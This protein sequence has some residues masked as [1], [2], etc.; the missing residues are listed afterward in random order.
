MSKQNKKQTIK[1]NTQLKETNDIELEYWFDT[2][3]TGCIRIID[4]NT[5]TIY[6]SDPKEKEWKVLFEYKPNTNKKTLL[7]DFTTKKTHRVH[8]KMIAIYKNNRNELHW[9]NDG[10]IWLRI[11]VNPE[12][13]LKYY[14]NKNKNKNM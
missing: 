4:H 11:R 3:H 10:N 12:N 6:G 14:K 8:K 7:I 5:Q 9:L 13:V 2:H 1:N